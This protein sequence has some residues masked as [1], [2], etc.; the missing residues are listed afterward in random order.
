MRWFRSRDIVKGGKPYVL[1]AEE[2]A[3]IYH[4]PSEMVA[5]PMVERPKAKKGAS[6]PNLPVVP[7]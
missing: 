1:N 5:A 3:T 4:F 7:E 6:P 2:L